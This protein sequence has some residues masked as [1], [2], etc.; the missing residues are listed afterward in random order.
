MKGC[1]LSCV[2]CHNPESQSPMVQLLYTENKCI[3]CGVCVQVC[4]H[5]ACTLTSKEIV[6]DSEICVLCGECAEACPT[7]SRELSGRQQTVEEVVAAIE[8]ERV[9]FEQ[10]GGGVTFSGG[11]PLLHAELLIQLLDACGE[12]GIHRAVDTA[13]LADTR[14]LLEVAKRTDLFLYDLKMMNPER[15]QKYTGV[16]NEKIL[17]NLQMLAKTGAD[18]TIR[19]PLI[20]NINDD[21]ENIERTAAFIASLEGGRKRKSINLLPYHNIAAGK[22]KK[23]GAWYD[24]M[25]MTAPSVERQQ[26]IIDIFEA[27]GLEATIGG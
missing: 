12:K 20:K 26:K 11:E 15:H 9:F 3:G 17:E 13:G 4:K 7:A 24:D 1:P 2:W 25:G 8:K 18:I 19:I 16:R 22:Y 5:S 10:S 23:L 14:T 27:H 21:N 6:T